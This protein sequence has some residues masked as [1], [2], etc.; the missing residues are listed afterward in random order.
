[1]PWGLT[2]RTVVLDEKAL[3]FHEQA[4]D[5]NCRFDDQWAAVEWLLSKAPENGQFRDED[6]PHR[7]LIYVVPADELA[8]TKE[9]WVLYS[10]DSQQVTVHAIRFYP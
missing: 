10:Y 2:L 5:R 6:Y 1:M 3:E 8:G 9:L 7:N 4:M